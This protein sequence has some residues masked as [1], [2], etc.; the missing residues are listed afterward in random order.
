MCIML[1]VIMS[2]VNS[3]Q[4]AFHALKDQIGA[5]QHSH[6]KDSDHRS[7]YQKDSDYQT[8]NIKNQRDVIIST[9][10]MHLHILQMRKS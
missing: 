4:D 8:K 5:D 7:E 3:I 10:K 9:S 6:G 1:S 2:A